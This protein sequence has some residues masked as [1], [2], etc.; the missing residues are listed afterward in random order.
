MM[1]T[2]RSPS[3]RVTLRAILLSPSVPW[4]AIQILGVSYFAFWGCLT[5]YFLSCQGSLAAATSIQISTTTEYSNDGA[6]S[7]YVYLSTTV[8]VPLLNAEVNG[9]T[10][11]MALS[12]SVSLPETEELFTEDG[13]DAVVKVYDNTTTIEATYP[14]FFSTRERIYSVSST[15]ASPGESITITYSRP[16]ERVYSLYLAL[17]SGE[18]EFEFQQQE[19]SDFATVSVVI[20]AGFPSGAATLRYNAS[21]RTD[22]TRCEG[23]DTCEPALSTANGEIELVIQ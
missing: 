8:C 9:A 4:M 1:S 6:V 5:A 14:G 18:S 13:P 23:V 3:R 12:S 20:P 7:E 10:A 2:T 16:E 15:T 22:A 17:Q 21:S 19:G 11:S